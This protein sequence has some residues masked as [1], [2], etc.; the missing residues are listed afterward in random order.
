MFGRLENFL[1][2]EDVEL[3]LQIVSR[4][5]LSSSRSSTAVQVYDSTTTF[6]PSKYTS[7]NQSQLKYKS[8]D[9]CHWLKEVWMIEI[10]LYR[11]T[12]LRRVG[13]AGGT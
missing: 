4:D 3:P 6:W 8:C 9:D 1:F 10:L 2:L 12:L 13:A 7:V 5:H 11:H